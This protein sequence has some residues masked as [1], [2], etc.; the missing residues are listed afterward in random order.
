MERGSINEF[1]YARRCQHRRQFTANYALHIAGECDRRECLHQLDL[2][3]VLG[4]FGCHDKEGGGRHRMSN[5]M[6][7]RVCTVDAL[8][9]I[10][11]RWQ[12]DRAH[13]MVAEVPIFV[14]LF[15]RSMCIVA[16]MAAR[17]NISSEIAQPH[18][19]AGIGQK[20]S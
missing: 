6:Y 15:S 19:V 18:V 20:E 5:E 11:H 3:I 2:C 10:D 8:N 14:A 12:I 9:V 4:Q 7:L 13:L 1:D 16:G 17:V